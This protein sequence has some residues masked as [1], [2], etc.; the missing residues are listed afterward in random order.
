M[1]S[2]RTA[3]RLIG[4]VVIAVLLAGTIAGVRRLGEVWR[5]TLTGSTP[6]DVFTP[7]DLVPVN[8][9]EDPTWRTDGM[10]GRPLDPATRAAIGTA[11]VE[12]WIRLDAAMRTTDTADLRTSWSGSALDQVTGMVDDV[13][14]G[15][16]VTGHDLEVVVFSADGSIAE[17]VA[18]DLR[19]RRWH[20]VDGQRHEIAS[21][22]RWRAVM[23]LLDGRWRVDV[24]RRDAV[25]P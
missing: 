5:T 8:G 16:S 12:S 23:R 13:P 10:L 20:T 6:A 17:V 24:I 11:W 4:L 19:V 25:T 18:H 22:E 14:S 15:M 1:T 21:V 2:A 7:T 3:K 9:S